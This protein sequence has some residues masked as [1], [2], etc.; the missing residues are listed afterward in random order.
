MPIEVPVSSDGV[1]L[2]WEPDIGLHRTWKWET[3]LMTMV[4]G[5]EQRIAH[6]DY[7]IESFDAVFILDAAQVIQLRA[8][9]FNAPSS[10][11]L[12]P[13]RPESMLVVAD[14]TSTTV[15]I[16]DATLVDWWV[17]GQRVMLE[18]V[19]GSQHASYVVTIVDAVATIHDAVPDTYLAGTT[20]IMPL[21]AIALPDG[22]KTALNLVAAG[23]WAFT[24]RALAPAA[25]ASGG[26]TIGAGGAIATY[27]DLILFDRHQ[28][29]ASDDLTEQTNQ[30]GLQVIDYGAAVEVTS[31]RTLSTIQRS[32]TFTFDSDGERQW[33]KAFLAA[34]RGRQVS[35]LLPT[36]HEDLVVHTQ[37]TSTALVVEAN[38][39]VGNYVTD[40]WPSRAHRWIRCAMTD[41][42]VLVRRITAAVDNLDGTLGLTLDVA[43]DTASSAPDIVRIEF[44][45]RCRLADDAVTFEYE[46]GTTTSVALTFATVEDALP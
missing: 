37:P 12:F 7:P 3:D 11:F 43:I 33:W 28:A 6:Y 10:T 17:T 45:Q 22:Q 32:H 2:S 21:I 5:T 39:V 35:F 13:D 44:L 15:D 14:V 1:V 25:L 20:R 41:G 26:P 34:C 27:D 31:L 4:D 36:W 9:L 29:L 8:L 38:D 40:W 24:A 42:S 18:G 19:D 16:G 30:G 23:S 46:D